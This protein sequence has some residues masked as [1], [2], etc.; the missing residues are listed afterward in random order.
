MM[1]FRTYIAPSGIQGNGLFAAEPIPKGAKIWSFV[2]HFDVEFEVNSL[3]T[4]PELAQ[5]YLKRYT[6]PH[7]KKPGIVILDGDGG[8]F[9]N[10]SD[11][12]NTNFATPDFGT[13]LV[14]IA[15]GEELTCDYREFN[16]EIDF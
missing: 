13:A 6:Y 7:P 10:H 3:E 12:P 4:F 5:E 1:L 11:T 16:G 2:P 8:R 14:D 15:E 9:M